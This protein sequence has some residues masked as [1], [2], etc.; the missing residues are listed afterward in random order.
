MTEPT[1]VYVLCIFVFC[2]DFCW[3]CRS[4]VQVEAQSENL[5]LRE[6]K[7]HVIIFNGLETADRRW[8]ALLQSRPA[9]EETGSYTL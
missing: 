3:L 4:G 8:A 9:A 7:D 6:N 2:L 5:S 1:S